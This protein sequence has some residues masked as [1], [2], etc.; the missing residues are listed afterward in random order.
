M[1]RAGLAF[2]LKT[3]LI[4]PKGKLLIWEGLKLK[5]VLEWGFVGCVEVCQ[6]E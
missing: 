5:T 3:Q 4:L 6:E 2:Y 1:R